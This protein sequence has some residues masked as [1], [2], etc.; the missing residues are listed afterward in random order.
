MATR[1]SSGE[2]QTGGSQSFKWRA[3]E[4]GRLRSHREHPTAD[5]ECATNAHQLQDAGL[6]R[7]QT[8]IEAVSALYHFAPRS[9]S[10][11]AISASGSFPSL[12]SARHGSSPSIPIITVSTYT[13]VDHGPRTYQKP[14]GKHK[15]ILHLIV[16][17]TAHRADTQRSSK[18]MTIP[19]AT[20]PVLPHGIYCPSVSFFRST[21][22]QEL[23]T[24]TFTK[25]VEF[26]AKSGLQGIV[27]GGSNGEAVALDREEMVEVSRALRDAR[28][29]LRRSHD[30][31]SRS[32]LRFSSSTRRKGRSLLARQLRR[33]REK[34]S[35][36]RAKQRQLAPSSPSFSRQA[37]TPEP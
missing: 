27:I 36:E 22:E 14:A 10:A 29:W 11:S 37:T 12:A 33:Q 18:A 3:P 17:P 15:H 5:E 31:R 34:P 9:V 23:D 7:L 8:N 26:L 1:A 35:S 13:N 28:P 6:G 16:I 4:S 2:R 21:A 32:L 25:H 30:S 24:E 20:P 19:P